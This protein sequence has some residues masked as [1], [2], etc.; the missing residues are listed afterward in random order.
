MV[1][2]CVFACSLLLSLFF[3]SILHVVGF[4]LCFPHVRTAQWT[5]G[6]KRGETKRLVSRFSIY[7]A[8]FFFSKLSLDEF[9]SPLLR[10]SYICDS[11]K[12]MKGR[13]YKTKQKTWSALL[14]VFLSSGIRLLRFCTNKQTKKSEVKTEAKSSLH[15]VF[16][17]SFFKYFY[18]AFLAFVFILSFSPDR[19]FL[20]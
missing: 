10:L 1:F 20:P 19:V 7:I 4:P 8:V 11:K 9:T 12:K 3:C 18:F 6:K 14:F 2:F 17:A 15:C 5:L 13:N 16:C